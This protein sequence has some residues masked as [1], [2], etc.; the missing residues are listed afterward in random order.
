MMIKTHC[1]LLFFT[2]LALA[3][4]FSLGSC[5]HIISFLLFNYFSP[6]MQ[7]RQGRHSDDRGTDVERSGA[8][9]RRSQGEASGR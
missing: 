8:T 7:M 3:C 5:L 2:P 9:D 6:C 1:L 4:M